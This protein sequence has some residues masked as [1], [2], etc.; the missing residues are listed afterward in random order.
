[1]IALLAAVSE[2][3]RLLR[4]SL[5]DPHID[6]T[7]GLKVWSGRLAGQPV[8]LA[9]AGIG[10]AAA[11]AAAMTLLLRGPVEELWLFGCGG[12]YP[13]SGL[14]IGDLALA[15]REVFGDDGVET[16]DGFQDLAELGLPMRKLAGEPCFNSWPLDPALPAWAAPV[17]AQFAAQA[18]CKLGVGPFVT[19]S[20]C[21]GTNATAN[22]LQERTGGLCEN[23][24]GAAVAL[25]C[26]QTGAR[27]LELRGIS[28]R[29]EARDP[30][31]WDLGAGMAIAQRAVLHLLGSRTG[32]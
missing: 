10:K 18:G 17:L 26:R 21:T 20:T 1:M 27:L 6:S 12:A 31:A 30:A 15:D 4:Q 32:A 28:N 8:L 5:D 13:A 29:V 11:A 24:E 2:E 3:T 19:V 14:G 25:A 7:A 9:H 23:M 16:P 22:A